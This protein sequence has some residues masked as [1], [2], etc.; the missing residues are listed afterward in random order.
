MFDKTSAFCLFNEARSASAEAF[1]SSVA[2]LSA[3]N[4]LSAASFS[5]CLLA[6]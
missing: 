6:S 2:I 4:F 3:C 5:A 1:E